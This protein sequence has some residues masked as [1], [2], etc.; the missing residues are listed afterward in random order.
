[1]LPVGTVPALDPTTTTL[2]VTSP[3]GAPTVVEVTC[4]ALTPE[5]LFGGDG[6]DRVAP[7][8]CGTEAQQVRLRCTRADD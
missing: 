8:R 4:P 7:I 1:M 6:G 5:D 3:T 2:E